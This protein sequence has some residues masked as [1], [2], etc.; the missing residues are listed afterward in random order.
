M[1]HIEGRMK[2]HIKG[3]IKGHMK[4]HIKGHIKGHVKEFEGLS[5]SRSHWLCISVIYAYW[6]CM[7]M[8]IV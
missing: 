5:K 8:K 4:G 7:Y 6:S 1:L 2:G 3:P